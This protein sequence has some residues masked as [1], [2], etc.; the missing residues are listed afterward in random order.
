MKTIA[1]YGVIFCLLLVPIQLF[2]Q[3]T[4]TTQSRPYE[5][6]AAQIVSDG[7]SSGK[8][9][10]LLQELTG[11]IGARLSGSPQASRAVEWGK[12]TM[13]EL[14]FQNVHLESFMVPHWVRGTVE[15]ATIIRSSS[16]RIAVNVCAL[17]GSI[18]TPEAGIT[19]EVVEVKSFDELH[20]LGDKAKGKIIFFNRPLD[21]TKF[22]TFEAYGGAVD[23]RGQ[24]AVEAAKVGG[25]A[26]LV[27]SMTTRLDDVPHTGAMRYNDSIP[28]VPAAA[29]STIGANVLD[30]ILSHAKRVELN[31]KLGCQSLPDVESANVVGELTGTEKPNEVIVIGGHL[32]SWDKGQGA[33]DD[34]AG[35]VQ[36]LETLRL[37]KDLGLKPKRTIRAVLF[38]NEE[39]GLRG[40]KAYAEKERPGERHIAAIETDAGGFSPRGFGVQADSLAIPK[41]AQWSY[42]FRRID[43]DRI[44]RGGG[45]ADISELGKKGVPAIGLRVDGQKYFD[46]HH[47]DNDTIDKVNERELELGATALAILS[48]VLAQEGI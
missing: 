2:G 20:A 26:A 23:Q 27:R 30:S 35:S 9:F 8:A 36:S 18:G 13:E 22:N 47:S 1:T 10:K 45:G 37:L 19:A 28:K 32:D 6:V 43:A 38:M 24:G 14:G 4:D 39:N 33:H 29:I 46:Y 48:Y 21:K 31:L 17:G 3:R 7:L 11:K 44:E 16:E 25:V 12:K 41:V 40:G 42:L 34:G 15:S 5:T